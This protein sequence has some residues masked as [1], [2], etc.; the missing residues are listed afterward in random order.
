MQ[1]VQM[2]LFEECDKS[3]LFSA[4]AVVH[5]T[6]GGQVRQEWLSACEEER[7]LTTDLME[8]VVSPL[9]LG[10]KLQQSNKQQRERRYRQNGS[11]GIKQMATG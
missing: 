7:A 2:N 1:K 6:H 8:K 11:K 3:I 9:N 4:E 5:R 10:I